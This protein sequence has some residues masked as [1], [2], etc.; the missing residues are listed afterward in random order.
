MKTVVGFEEYV[1]VL[2]KKKTKKVL[3]RID[4][5]ATRTSID[6]ALAK[7]LGLGPVV[8]YMKVTSS[9]GTSMRGLVVARIRIANRTFKVTCALSDRKNMNYSIL[10]GRNILKHDFVVDSAKKAGDS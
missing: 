1:T 5:G 4:T 3:A 2:G 7:T 10:I 9:H 8:R 6:T